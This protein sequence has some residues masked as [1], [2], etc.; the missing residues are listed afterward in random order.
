MNIIAGLEYQRIN[1]NVREINHLYKC[2]DNRWP[3][4]VSLIS[5]SRYCSFVRIGTGLSYADYI[6]IRQKPWKLWGAN[7]PSWLQVARKGH[8]DK[9]DVYLEPQE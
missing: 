6:W 4:S 1:G 8:E 9:G 3:A 2:V 7:G 5:F